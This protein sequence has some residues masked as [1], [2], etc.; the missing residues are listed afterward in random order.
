[1]EQL[2]FL[3]SLVSPHH[4][5]SAIVGDFNFLFKREEV[6]TTHLARHITEPTHVLPSRVS[7]SLSSHAES[8]H[9]ERVCGRVARTLAD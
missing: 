6:L 2:A 3:D 8:D 7:L 5:T 9:R 4:D 1:M